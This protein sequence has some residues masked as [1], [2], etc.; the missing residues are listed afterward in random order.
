MALASD[1]S[2]FYLLSFLICHFLT[3]EHASAT[4]SEHNMSTT[5]VKTPTSLLRQQNWDDFCGRVLGYFKE[6][7]II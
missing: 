2:I 6:R 5:Q 1:F 3:P 7:S 4:N